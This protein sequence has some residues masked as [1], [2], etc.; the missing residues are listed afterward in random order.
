M[1]RS[2]FRVLHREVCSELP[3]LAERHHKYTSRELEMLPQ[4]YYGIVHPIPIDKA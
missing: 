2:S 3:K 4:G 1:G